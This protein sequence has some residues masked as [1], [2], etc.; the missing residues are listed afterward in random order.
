VFP[1]ECLDFGVEGF[2][3]VLPLLKQI[4]IG[5]DL[6]LVTL[7]HLAQSVTLLLLLLQLAVQ[8]QHFLL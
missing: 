2:G 8:L 1:L 3:I 4:T 6:V 7:S 5:L